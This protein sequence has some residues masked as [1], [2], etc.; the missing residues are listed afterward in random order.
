MYV[1]SSCACADDS[2]V[3]LRTPVELPELASVDVRQLFDISNHFHPW[4]SWFWAKLGEFLT[5]CTRTTALS[6]GACLPARDMAMAQRR[7]FLD[8]AT[9]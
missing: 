6:F 8:A 4:I 2:H 9:S 3:L 5:S 1:C 7:T